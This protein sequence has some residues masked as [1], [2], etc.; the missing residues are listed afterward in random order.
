[1]DFR[2]KALYHQIHPLKL[3]TDW[4]SAVVAAYLLWQH[5]L[6]RALLVG[7]L[8]PA[9]VSALLI[10]YADRESSKVSRVG[11]YVRRYMTPAMEV[12]RLTGGVLFWVG[13]WLHMWVFALGGLAL[14]VLAWMRG[15]LWPGS[16]SDPAV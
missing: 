12:L 9:A 1:M 2:E 5:H 15:R 11:R 10:R 3:L 6:L 14:V 16:M 8:P 7:L 4:A 13:A